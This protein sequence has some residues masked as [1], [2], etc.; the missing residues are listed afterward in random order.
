MPRPTPSRRSSPQDAAREFLEL[1]E[2][3]LPLKTPLSNTG[4]AG[5]SLAADSLKQHG[6]V[7]PTDS[8]DPLALETYV[9]DG[10]NSYR[11][12]LERYLR[13][14][15][16]EDYVSDRIRETKSSTEKAFGERIRGAF[17]NM[18]MDPHGLI[19]N[20]G[21]E[22]RT[23]VIRAM[24]R[25]EPERILPK[26]VPVITRMA[27]GKAPTSQE[28]DDLQYAQLILSVKMNAARDMSEDIAQ[29]D[30]LVM[31]V[32]EGFSLSPSGP[33][34]AEDDNLVRAHEIFN[35]RMEAEILTPIVSALEQVNRSIGNEPVPPRL[36]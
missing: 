35:N 28:K 2:K 18:H 21:E 15:E 6:I 17:S 9:A 11:D 36:R 14:Y 10:D 19:F 1:M 7:R 8:D 5:M 4:G 34:E 30:G 3:K 20:V 12:F 23:K 31:A 24:E 32:M 25:F 26:L 29:N 27:E 33:Q 16:F 22:I 13:H